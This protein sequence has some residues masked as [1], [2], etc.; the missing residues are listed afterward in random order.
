MPVGTVAGIALTERGTRV[1]MDINPGTVVPGDVRS[2]VQ[3][4]ND[5][6][7]QV[8]DLVPAHGGT[9]PAL[10]SG[11]HVPAAPDQ[12]PANVGAVVASA[13][14][15][16]QDIPAGDLNKLISEMATALKGRAG[17]LRTLVS[18]GTTFSQEFVAFEHQFRALLA[19][20][21]TALN[22]TTAIAPELKQ[23]LANTSALL[24]VLAQNKNGLHT[25]FSSGSTALD[26][27]HQ[28]VTSQSAN[29][30]CFLHDSAGIL[31]NIAQP[32]NLTNLSQGLTYNESFFGAVNQVAV[33]GLAKTTTSNAPS[34]PHQ[35]FLRTKIAVPPVVAPQAS[36][37]ATPNAI[38]DVLPGAGCVTVYGDGV[39]P[40][41]QP[42]FVPAAG[43]HVV[44]PSAQESNV[45]LPG[46]S[47]GP[48][49]TAA[50]TAPLPGQWGLVAMG[51][52]VVPFLFLLW[53][54]AR[55]AAAPGAGP[56][57]EVRKARRGARDWPGR[58]PRRGRPWTAA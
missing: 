17:D 7:E 58:R 36:T 52:L 54:R 33:P 27:V 26:Q 18:A 37:Y 35:L 5:L 24:A 19:N 38:P 23:D 3:I 13:T 9:A 34:N 12:I 28:L 56:R 55:R 11:A 42:G 40:A 47:A 44:A 50:Y 49:S 14:R 2:S 6:G 46:P 22:T 21:P 39:G 32:T 25:L 1:T 16:L 4:A 15:L 8:V 53:G 20:S 57:A 29:L 10:R 51:G 43:G 48:S 45:E 31:S 41:T 30:G